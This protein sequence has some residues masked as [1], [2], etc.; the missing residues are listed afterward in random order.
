MNRNETHAQFWR[1]CC[2]ANEDLN[3]SSTYD[4]WYFGDSRELADN[5]VELVLA[6]NK[7]ATAAL[8]WEADGEDTPPLPGDISLVTNY[9]GDPKC[10]IRY[11]GISVLPF[12]QVDAQF[13]FDEGEGDRSLDYWRAAHWAFFSRY[14]ATIGR[15]PDLEMPVVCK[16]FE[17]L[18]PAHR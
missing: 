8:A 11:T 10:F 18:Y 16:R 2:E 13:A 1:R 15:K 12:N 5:L 4:V 3:P 9:D 17:V 14:C 7:R 6:G